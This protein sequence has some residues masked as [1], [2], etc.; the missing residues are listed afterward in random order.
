MNACRDTPQKRS[1]PATLSVLTQHPREPLQANH[2]GSRCETARGTRAAGRAPCAMLFPPPASPAAK[3]GGEI[4]ATP[5]HYTLRRGP[6][7]PGEGAPRLVPR[8]ARPERG[9]DGAQRVRRLEGLLQGVG[10]VEKL[11]R[12]VFDRLRL[13]CCTSPSELSML[14]YVQVC[15][16]KNQEAKRRRSM[17]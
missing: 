1:S 5:K 10:A 8:Q 6:G 4:M 13:L 17:R 11:W 14:Q 3:K 7:G 2:H 12:T 9:R 16:M 15:S